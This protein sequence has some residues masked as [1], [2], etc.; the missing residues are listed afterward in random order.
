MKR[1]IAGIITLVVA[2][3]CAVNLGGPRPR[4]FQT[5][6]LM[7]GPDATAEA[8]ASTI[9]ETGAAVVLLTAERD[10]AWFA[11]V[12]SASGLA[13][14][15]PGTTERIAKAF[16]TNM[17]ILGDTSIVLG[18]SD[19]SRMHVHDALYRLD[20]GRLVDL[21]LVGLQERSDLRDAARALLGYI[22]TDVGPNASLIIA[23]H[24][25]TAAAADSMAVLIRAA[26]SSAWECA[27]HDSAANR[28]PLRLFYGPSARMSCQ[29]AHPLAGPD[30][31]I[32]ALLVV[33][34]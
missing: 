6:A 34:R 9:R 1:L 18:V 12:S 31:A 29:E 21:M 25:P 2:G 3:G 27:G 33:E 13:L 8:V 7:A 14:S 32:T 5:L 24:A 22:A 20:R 28:V 4:D 23:L 10:S 30:A 26:Y 11:A 17:E 15:G 16:L 19:G